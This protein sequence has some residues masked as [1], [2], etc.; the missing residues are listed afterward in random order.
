MTSCSFM[1]LSDY[2]SVV[3]HC[4]D[5]FFFYLRNI[6][7]SQV[8]HVGCLTGLLQSI[9]V[10]ELLLLHYTKVS[11]SSMICESD[12]LNWVF[13]GQVQIHNV[14]KTALPSIGTD[15]CS[16]SRNTDGFIMYNHVLNPEE[17]LISWSIGRSL[18]LRNLANYWSIWAGL[19]TSD[20]LLVQ[21]SQPY[22]SCYLSQFQKAS[23][24]TPVAL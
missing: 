9:T 3:F 12:K 18:Y 7:T 4:L 17:F 24:C 6:W 15:T 23:C 1:M 11:F 2:L 8:Q 22:M 20:C 19:R 5:A 10:I 13:T 14:Q 16:Q 21:N